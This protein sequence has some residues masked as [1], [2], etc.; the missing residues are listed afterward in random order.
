MFYL[1]FVK[2]QQQQL[3]MWNMRVERF[4]LNR[5]IKFARR[6]SRRCNSKYDWIFHGRSI[7]Y[8]SKIDSQI[9][10]VTVKRTP[11]CYCC[12]C[13]KNII[14]TFFIILVHAGIWDAFFELL[15]VIQFSGRQLQ[16]KEPWIN[17]L[18]SQYWRELKALFQIL[19]SFSDIRQ[20]NVGVVLTKCFTAIYLFCSAVMNFKSFM[21]LTLDLRQ[22]DTQCR[23]LRNLLSPIFRETSVKSTHS[24]LFYAV[25]CFHEILRFSVK[26]T[27]LLKSWFHGIFLSAL[28]SK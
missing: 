15:K 20:T 11:L 10:L 5:K 25:W 13:G 2:Q 12:P 27:I 9:R 6:G 14:H 8:R 24:E 21:R 18:V 19:F 28:S 22:T 7:Y 16:T 26:S 23:K 1:F 3:N 4:L 17:V